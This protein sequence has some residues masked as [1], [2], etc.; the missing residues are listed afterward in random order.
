MHTKYLVRSN[1]NNIKIA[2]KFARSLCKT[3]HTANTNNA[4]SPVAQHNNAQVTVQLANKVN[5]NNVNVR[6]NA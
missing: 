1:M 4:Q 2:Q 6:Q 3:T 5:M